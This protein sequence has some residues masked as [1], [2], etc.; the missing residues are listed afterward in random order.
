[1]GTCAAGCRRVPPGAPSSSTPRESQAKFRDGTMCIRVLWVFGENSFYQNMWCIRRGGKRTS[2]PGVA[3]PEV[4]ILV[5]DL[6]RV[7]GI[8]A[9]FDQGESIL[10]KNSFFI[11][12][13]G[14]N[15]SC[16]MCPQQRYAKGEPSTVQGRNRVGIIEESCGYRT[17]RVSIGEK[18]VLSKNQ[19]TR[20]WGSACG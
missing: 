8:V 13:Q 5:R 16:A 12:S 1:M 20:R 18:F 4:K 2:Y 15:V 7:V 11:E 10:G 17:R 19:G 14:V 6:V 3:Y 9:H